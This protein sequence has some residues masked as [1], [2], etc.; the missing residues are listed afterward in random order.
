MSTHFP[1]KFFGSME[2]EGVPSYRHTMV[3]TDRLVMRAPRLEDYTQ[4]CCIRRDN[5]DHIQPFDPK[6]PDDWD[7]QDNH[8]ARIAY[9]QKQWRG[10]RAYVFLVID[11][12]R[13]DMIGG[14]H[15][16]QVARGPAQFASLGYWIAKPQEGLG[17]MSEAID[18]TV[19]FCFDVLKLQRVQAATVMSNVRSQVLLERYGFEREGI[20]KQYAEINGVREDHVL[21]GVNR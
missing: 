12:V 11:R 19:T 15:I 6:W 5:Q 8:Q 4:W 3:T 18:A 20:A 7:N 17:L 21:Y 2:V 1:L 9:Y 13:Q 14:V 10:D 16:N